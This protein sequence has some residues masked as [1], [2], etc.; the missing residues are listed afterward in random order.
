M[1]N[2]SVPVPAPA[3]LP[4]AC[5]VPHCPA[6][7]RPAL[8][9]IDR[10]IKSG[11]FDILFTALKGFRNGVVY[12]ARVRA[13]H[14]LV[15]NL[16]WSKAP[17][18][19]IPAK[20]FSVTK[21]HAIGLG[22]SSVIFAVVR[23][24]LRALQGREALWHTTLAGF[25]LGAVCWGDVGSAVHMQMMMY[26]LSRI[27]CAWYHLVVSRFS[28]RV[29]SYAFRAYMGAL[30]AITLTLLAVRPETLQSSMRHSLAYIFTDSSKF[31]SWYDVFVVNTADSM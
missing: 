25:L 19:T 18:R 26:M 20:I 31:S 23:G 12:G 8:D 22:F 15:L 10:M 29:P 27:V 9:M 17:Y 4:S 6:V 2:S 13:P 14:A 16:V 3:A 7:C 30:Y 28:L 24:A 5:R 21:A 1:A 11:D